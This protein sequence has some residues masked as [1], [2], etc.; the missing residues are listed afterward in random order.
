MILKGSGSVITAPEEHLNDIYITVL[1]HS[2]PS[3]YTDEEKEEAYGMVGQVL[4]GIAI[5]S[6]P[7]SVSSLSRLLSLPIE[8]INQT[9]D[10]LYSVLDVPKD[11]T[12]PLRLHHP[13]FRDFLLNK[14]RCKDSNFWVDEKQAHQTIAD[15][16][17][18]V[19]STS[20]KQDICDLDAP[21]VLITDVASNRVEQCLPPEV[22]YACLYWIQHLQKSRAQLRDNDQV[23]QFLQEHLLHWFEALGWMGKVSEGIHAIASLETITTASKP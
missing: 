12:H 15:C 16:C 10:E 7:L 17:V 22:Q 4:G 8:D 21:G 9:L 19:M 11:K 13:S 6:S 1:K 20:L 14:D 5:L 23:H 3:G 18:E 2:I